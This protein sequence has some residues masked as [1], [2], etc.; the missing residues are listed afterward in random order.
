MSLLLLFFVCLQIKF[1]IR[2]WNVGILKK[3]KK[4]KKNDF[5]MFV[6]GWWWSRRWKVFH[7]NVARPQPRF[8]LNYG[9]FPA[10]FQS[11]RAWRIPQF[12]RLFF[13]QSY[14]DASLSTQTKAYGFTAKFTVEL[15]DCILQF[16]WGKMLIRCSCLS[17][18]HDPSMTY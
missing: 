6:W 7:L 2:Q 13:K 8:T 10:F 3:K 12:G 9:C 1:I 15:A 14:A 5:L 17:R 4:H 16:F 11:R 18:F